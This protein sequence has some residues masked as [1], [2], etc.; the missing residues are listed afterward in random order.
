MLALQ[1]SLISGFPFQD[2]SLVLLFDQGFVR[3]ILLVYCGAMGMNEK[4]AREKVRSQIRNMN[5]SFLCLLE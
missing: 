1:D 4:Q 5:I 3:Q 2:A